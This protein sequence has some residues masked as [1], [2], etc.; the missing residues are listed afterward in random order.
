[1]KSLRVSLCLFGLMLFAAQPAT[2]AQQSPNTAGTRP[3]ARDFRLNVD[4]VVVDAQVLQKKTARVV[5]GLR[6]EDFVVYEDGTKQQLTQFSQES[7]PLSVILLVDRG[8]SFGECFLPGPG[9]A[10]YDPFTDTIRHAT[11]EA[12]SRLRPNDEVALMAFG[13]RVELISA[14]SK[15]KTL[16]SDAVYKVPTLKQEGDGK[17][18]GPVTA[19]GG[20]CFNMAL[21]AASRFMREAANPEGRRVIIMV[22]GTMLSLDC[23]PPESRNWPASSREAH[24]ELFATGTL[25]CGLIPTTIQQQ[26][27]EGKW[28]VAVR[29][30]VLLDKGL[31]R[32]PLT[33]L[34][35]FAEETGGEMFS[36]KP[37][38]ID[39]AFDDLIDHLRNR[40]TLGFVSSNTKHDGRIRKLKVD[41]SPEARAR[42]GE[43]VVKARRAYVAGKGVSEG[44]R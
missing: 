43:V 10:S 1:M 11:N 36:S 41:L 38:D 18:S 30:N 29:N 17:V 42:E 5:G 27:D 25:V 26:T 4:M 21:W 39:R 15:D 13:D 24:E 6:M 3:G 8:T 34:P 23:S 12:L 40:Y 31:A 20:R 9:A 33:S 2:T 14:F 32:A 44:G 19:Q 7:L 22:T 35:Q 37:A 16:I 28:S